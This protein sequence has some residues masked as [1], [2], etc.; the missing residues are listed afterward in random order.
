MA[1]MRKFYI[2]ILAVVAASVLCGL[3]KITGDMWMSVTTSVVAMY[4]IANI[5]GK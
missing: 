3:G 5:S 2:A 1:H 4:K